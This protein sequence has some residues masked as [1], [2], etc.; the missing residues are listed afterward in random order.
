MLVTLKLLAF[1]ASDLQN[2]KAV[3]E[4]TW[5]VRETPLET[6]AD[7]RRHTAASHA[8][9]IHIRVLISTKRQR[10][11]KIILRGAEEGGCSVL[12]AMLKH[13]VH[14]HTS[15]SNFLNCPPPP[16]TTAQT[17][18]DIGRILYWQT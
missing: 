3:R 10:E 5:P 15:S 12:F 8:T 13:R 6:A 14:S 9:R 4:V 2:P 11:R 1:V 7:K 17:H 16:L 18:A